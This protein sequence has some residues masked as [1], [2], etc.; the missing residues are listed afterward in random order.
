MSSIVIVN[1]YFWP[2][3]VLV[4]DIATW[5]VEAGHEVEVITSQ[6]SYNPEARLPKRPTRE[7]WNGVTVRRISL[8][9]ER[10]R[11]LVRQL[12][13][14]L[15]CWCAALLVL[16]G[17]RHRVVWTT[18]IPPVLQPLLL[19]IVT[20]LRGSQLI[21]F[22]Q[23]IYPEIAILMGMIKRGAFTGLITRLDNWTI[24]R[25]DVVV[26]LS[27]DMA[28]SI[29]A[30]GVVPRR[31]LHINNFSAI[32]SAVGLPRPAVD[33]PCRFVFAGNIGRFQHLEQ[34]IELFA[35]IDPA[36]GR[37]ELIGEGRLKQ[38]LEEKVLRDGIKSVFF[39]AY[40]PAIEAFELIRDRD[41]G[42]VSLS[43]GLYAYAYPSKTFTYLAAGVPLL[44][45]IEKQSELARYIEERGIGVAVDWSVPR[46]QLL[47][48]I[49]HVIVTHREMAQNLGEK[50]HDLYDRQAARLRWTALFDE[51][52]ATDRRPV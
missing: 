44:C 28:D 45:F 42:I 46:A 8:L 20:R 30:R 36:E 32:E 49:Q 25:A 47:E 15:F 11:G 24:S 40:R 48:A 34:T 23:D 3:T 38:A 12:N 21:Y 17:R 43:P 16:F 13:N 26:T 18:S 35:D 10:K 29:K 5:L 39:H 52:L 4:N 37:L 6:P 9:P 7:I 31:L 1:R 51:L 50:R 2:E 41:V 22:V 33:G 19:R 27:N 14:L